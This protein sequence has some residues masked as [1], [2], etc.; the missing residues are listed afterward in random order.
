[1][2]HMNVDRKEERG[3]TGAGYV[4]GTKLNKHKII[5]VVNIGKKDDVT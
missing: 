1:M 4:P 2:S 3:S 5:H